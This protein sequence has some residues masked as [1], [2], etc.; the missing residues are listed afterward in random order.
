MSE[1]TA[2][3]VV[4]LVRFQKFSELIIQ[5]DTITDDKENKPFN[6]LAIYDETVKLISG[7]DSGIID[8]YELAMKTEPSLMIKLLEVKKWL[9][10]LE[11][12][13]KTSH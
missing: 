4:N 9:K 6:G 3:S 8:Q 5:I 11:P 13:V 2:G 1:L 12:L 7:Q 10:A